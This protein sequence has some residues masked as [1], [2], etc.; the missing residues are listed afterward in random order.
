MS[1]FQTIT[2]SCFSP[3][4]RN[5]RGAARCPSVLSKFNE[6]KTAYVPAR[7]RQA[8]EGHEKLSTW[9]WL[10]V[11]HSARKSWHLLFTKSA[12]CESGALGCLGLLLQTCDRPCHVSVLMHKTLFYDAA[13]MSNCICGVRFFWVCVFFSSSFC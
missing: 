9:L 10:L 4:T 13:V 8:S 2:F 12:Q 11:Q 7:P 6:H 3:V 1:F 5:G